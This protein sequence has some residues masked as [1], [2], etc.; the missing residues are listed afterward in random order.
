MG[1]ETG[2]A[3]VLPVL[4]GRY[5]LQRRLDGGGMADMYRADDLALRRPV[6]VK[7]LKRELA[8][9]QDLLQRFRLEAQAAAQ[10]NHPNVVAVYDRGE[11]DDS[12]Y[13]VMEYVRG[14]TVKQRLWRRGRFSPEEA[15]GIA[16][17]V[18]AAL[19]AAH[20]R[21]IVHR[22]VTSANVMLDERDQVKVMD[23]GIARIGAPVLT[24][25]GTILGTSSYLSPEQA[26]G[27][28]ADERSD[29]YG[30][31]VVLFEMLTGRLPFTGEG[32]V[33]VAV[34]HISEPPPDPRDF[35]PDLPEVLCA[36]TRRA[37]SKDPDDRYQTAAEFASALRRVR[38]P[39]PRAVRES[40]AAPTTHA[41]AATSASE[42]AARPPG[43]LSEATPS[44]SAPTLVGPPPAAAAVAASSEASTA[45]VSRTPPGR[46]LPSATEAAPVHAPRRRRRRQGLILF[47]GLAVIALGS[48]ALVAFVLPG[49]PSVPSVVGRIQAEAVAKVE[50][51]GL[52]A[53]VRRVWVDGVDAGAVARQRPAGGTRVDEGAQVT[54]WVSRG[55]LHIPAPDV[56]GADASAARTALD[57]QALEGE[58]RKT[59]SLSAPEGQVIRQQPA[60]GATV[61]RGDTIIYWVSSGPPLA[62][63]PDVVGKP[64]SDA[65]A[66]LEEAGFNA[67]I[68]LVVGWGAY[69]GDVVAQSPQ[70]GEQLKK[71]DEVVIEVAIL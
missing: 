37:L 71:G 47:L 22:D 48:W 20:E 61:A 27:R 21:H 66:I 65:V 3:E 41:T 9:D 39:A 40:S 60:A 30:L 18:L 13:I 63:V 19:Q 4:G 45:Y 55:D 69:P 12:A 46:S 34:Q 50:A 8:A 49:G 43:P 42:P 44:P 54:L 6:A 2:S 10:L 29:L 62:R 15:A 68:S 25:T 67:N 70:A 17:A 58:R 64:A 1:E 5:A 7:I 24:R 56:V 57:A 59:V 23:F 32:D 38:I 26:Q 33:A 35:A 52:E 11:T 36:I 53:V 31:G 51:Q 16:T 28:T 14:E